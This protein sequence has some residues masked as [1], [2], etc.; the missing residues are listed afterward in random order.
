[1]SSNRLATFAPNE[2]SIVITQNATGL[3]HVISG[4]A[5]NDMVAV[6]RAAETFKKYVGADNTTTR[7][8]NSDTSLTITIHLQQTS[9]SND[10]LTQLYLNDVAT[11]NGTFSILVKDNSGRSHYFAEEAYI[12]VVPNTAYA[13]SMQVHDW[14]IHAHN[15]TVFIGG[16]AKFSAEDQAAFEALGGTVSPQ[17]QA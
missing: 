17:W 4:Y 12:A 9:N 8:Y 11:R 5:E 13:N 3:T 2:I 7:I 10:I 1:M 14:V 16:N 15:S 6:E